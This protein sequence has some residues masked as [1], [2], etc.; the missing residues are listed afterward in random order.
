V[1]ALVRSQPPRPRR[2]LPIPKCT[3]VPRS[4]RAPL[5]SKLE[6]LSLRMQGMTR[7]GTKRRMEGERDARRAGTR[8]E[9][10]R[11]KGRRRK[12]ERGILRED[13][14]AREGA[15]HRQLGQGKEKRARG[16]IRSTRAAAG[17]RVHRHTA[18]PVRALLPTHLAAKAAAEL[19]KRGSGIFKH[20]SACAAS[21]PKRRWRPSALTPGQMIDRVQFEEQRLAGDGFPQPEPL[22][23]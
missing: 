18:H 2:R 14:K 20:A 7:P 13:A 3:L 10:E 4:M 9:A 23:S 12:S 15:N 16:D 1:C 6:L 5:S 11:A 8:G 19:Q 17:H 21:L 22:G